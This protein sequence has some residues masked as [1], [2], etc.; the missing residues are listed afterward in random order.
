MW[1]PMS[2]YGG[3]G[4]YGMG[5][6]GLLGGLMMVLFWGVILLLI[7]GVVRWLFGSATGHRQAHPSN[8]QRALDILDERYARGEIEREDYLR[9]REDLK[10]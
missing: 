8:S 2:G 6:Y 10:S 3:F 7:V 5:G 1:G 9:R 4:G